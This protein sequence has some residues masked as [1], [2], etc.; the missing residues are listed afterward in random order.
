MPPQER[1][2]EHRRVLCILAKTWGFTAREATGLAFWAW[3]AEQ[4]GETSARV[5]PKE[6]VGVG[7]PAAAEASRRAEGAEWSDRLPSS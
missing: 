6:P 1:E 4:R 2:T 5:V 3:L 7:G